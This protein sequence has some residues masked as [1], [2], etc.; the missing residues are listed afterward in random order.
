[1]IPLQIMPHQVRVTLKVMAM[2]VCSIFSKAPERKPRHQMIGVK[3]KTLPVVVV[4]V[5]PLCRDGI[6]WANNC[7]FGWFLR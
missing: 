7:S 1:M 6:G 3:S 2:A 5:L 4:G